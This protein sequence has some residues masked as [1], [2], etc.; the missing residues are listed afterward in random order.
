LAQY[1]FVDVTTENAKPTKQDALSF[2]NG[3]SV[4]GKRTSIAASVNLNTSIKT[5]SIK[6]AKR[7]LNSAKINKFRKL[8]KTVADKPLSRLVNMSSSSLER[9]EVAL[10]P[11]S[12]SQTGKHT[13][14]PLQLG[15]HFA[16]QDQSDH[17]E[18]VT[19]SNR[20]REEVTLFG[21]LEQQVEP[22]SS[23]IPLDEETLQFGNPAVV[24]GDDYEED[25]ENFPDNSDDLKVK[26]DHHLDEIMFEKLKK[27]VGSLL[28]ASKINGSES[29]ASQFRSTDH[30]DKESNWMQMATEMAA[31]DL[32]LQQMWLHVKQM[33]ANRQNVDQFPPANSTRSRN[34]KAISMETTLE[35]P[36]A[37]SDV[38]RPFVAKDAEDESINP[39]KAIQLNEQNA[40]NTSM[41]TVGSSVTSSDS[42]AGHSD[43]EL[44]SK[45]VADHQGDTRS[46]VTVQVNYGNRNKSRDSSEVDVS[47]L[48]AESMPSVQVMVQSIALSDKVT[49]RTSNVPFLVIKSVS[50]IPL[51]SP[52]VAL[53][54]KP[55]MRTGSDSKVQLSNTFLNSES[56]SSTIEPMMSESSAPLPALQNGSLSVQH[57]PPF[58]VIKPLK[59]FRVFGR[60]K[61]PISQSS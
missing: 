43:K 3:T 56:S 39:L 53:E 19:R 25:E 48:L 49:G 11:I 13:K 37:I 15:V 32:F 33:E 4:N 2:R 12:V 26:D 34:D 58:K 60:R 18:N 51:V 1:R 17:H 29:K 54:F 44:R 61:S 40:G 5:P 14:M 27:R 42:K 9:P 36:K 35:S 24:Q 38:N 8:S 47:Q 21:Q 31:K 20:E 52:G 10:Q 55:T 45:V 50:K 46:N 23:P 59:D 22:A 6:A 7:K 30:S 16:D 57:Q 28:N 41:Q